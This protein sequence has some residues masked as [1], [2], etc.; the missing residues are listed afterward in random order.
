MGQ[1]KTRTRGIYT[2]ANGS[3]T[4]SKT[5]RGERIFERL[6]EVSQEQAERWLHD[7]IE[8]RERERERR[9]SFRHLFA[10]CAAKY[11][12]ELIDKPSIETTA[13]HIRAVVPFVG[14]LDVEQIH[15][16][17]LEEFKASR[18]EEGV[19]PTTINRA[20]EV[21]RTILNR[22]ARVYRDEQGRPW[23]RQAPPLLTMEDEDS[24][25]PRPITWDE[26]DVLFSLLPPH[27]LNMAKFDVNTGLRDE[28]V[29]G[30]RWEWEVPVPEV[31]RSV[32][33]IPA[34][35]HKTGKKTKRAHVVILNDAAWSIIQ[36]QRGRHPEYVFVYRQERRKNFDMAP[37]MP[38]RRID[39]MN[40]SAW[41]TARK[42]AGLDGVRIH[43]LRHTCGTRLRAEG[44]EKEDRSALLGHASG[45]MAEHYAAA[46]IGRLMELSNRLL[47]RTG[48]QTV[49]SILSR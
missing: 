39:T 11:L 33:V 38:Y 7:E 5:W 19:S 42:K 37:V 12:T 13:I 28:N 36:E 1:T 44:V 26:Q 45:S 35:H 14:H 27:L 41:Q 18:R 24:R 21:V 3:K 16:G 49:I 48:T 10:E 29:C 8:K 22:A 47:K 2:E 25:P 20:L 30:L 4:V 6:G 34:A 15:D 32:F 23:L 46:D 17:T 43:D 40:N 9:E 31:G